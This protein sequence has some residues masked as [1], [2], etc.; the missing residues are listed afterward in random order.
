MFAPGVVVVKVT[1]VG[2]LIIPPAGE[3]SGA[4]TAMDPGLTVTKMDGDAEMSPRVS[5]ARAVKV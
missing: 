5:V 3:I 1:A 4:A 2:P